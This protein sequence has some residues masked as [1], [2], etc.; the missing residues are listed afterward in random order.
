MTRLLAHPWR[1]IAAAFTASAVLI[2]AGRALN[3]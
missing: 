2:A 3:H 1:H